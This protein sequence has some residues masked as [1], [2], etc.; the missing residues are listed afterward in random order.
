MQRTL[1]GLC[2][3]AA[4]LLKSSNSAGI[5]SIWGWIQTK[6]RSCQE[7]MKC[8]WWKPRSQS[9]VVK[10]QSQGSVLW[11]M[12]GLHCFPLLLHLLPIWSILWQK[13]GN[14]LGQ[15][16]PTNTCNKEQGIA[17][18]PDWA[19]SVFF[20]HLIPQEAEWDEKKIYCFLLWSVKSVFSCVPSWYQTYQVET[21]S[22][23]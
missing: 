1:Q 19:T 21:I 13:L 22:L 18:L 2:R 10:A 4:I 11:H 7:I 16:S 12:Q 3:I 14:A 6:Q 8:E 20:L 9:S 15:R 5:Q 23:V 17:V